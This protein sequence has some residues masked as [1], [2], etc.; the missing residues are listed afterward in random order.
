MGRDFHKAV[1][2]HH[3]LPIAAAS[4]S[5]DL[6]LVSLNGG[7]DPPAAMFSWPEDE[8]GEFETRK[9]DRLSRFHSWTV[10]H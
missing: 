8:D 10:V 5:G 7:S 3:Q 9:A 4:S 1:D 6:L 2:A